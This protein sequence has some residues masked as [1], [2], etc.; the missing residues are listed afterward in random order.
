MLLLSRVES[1]QFGV[2]NLLITFKFA[3]SKAD[4]LLIKTFYL[5]GYVGV[6]IFK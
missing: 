3:M 5:R 2:K 6:A 4:F 1:N